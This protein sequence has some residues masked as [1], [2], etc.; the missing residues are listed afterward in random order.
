MAAMK[1]KEKLTLL[2]IAAFTK[3]VSTAC[4]Y[5]EV[6]RKTYYQIK[7]AYDAGGIE[8]LERK[9][10]KVLNYKNRV[11]RDVEAEVLKFSY[12]IHGEGY[13]RG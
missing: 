9:N 2:E 3:N 5:M 11:P 8:A 4:E 1:L 13:S 12:I 6:S 10:R 7:K